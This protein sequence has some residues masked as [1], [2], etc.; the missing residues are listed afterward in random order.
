MPRQAY[1][2]GRYLPHREAAVHIEDRGYQF[3]DGVYEVVPVFNGALVDEDLHLDRLD[4]SLGELRIAQPMSRAA[5]K[6]VSRELMR[7]NGLSNGFLYMQVT[8]GVA[9][10]DHKFPTNARPALVMTTRQMK[11]HS[12][13]V[14]GEGL[15]VITVPDQR[16]DRC[17]IKSVSL[18]PNILGK[19]AAVEAGAYEAWQV[20]RDGMVTEGTS[21]NAWIVTQDNKVVT[22]DATHSILNGITRITLL[23]L[24]RKEGYELEERCFSVEEA[25]AAR[26]AFLTS[27]TSFVLPITQLDA[28]PIGNGHPG[29]LTGKLRQHYMDYMQSLRKSA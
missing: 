7:R 3:A 1:V 10:R 16:W 14:L 20:D 25:K 6:L 21:T 8:R 13:Q 17:D 29:I 12:E 9:P 24:I 18:L 5:L 15:K 11:P 27:S 19:Q 2:N 22:R 23:E 4:R 26:E 28:K